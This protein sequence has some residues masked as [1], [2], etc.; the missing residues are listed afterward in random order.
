MKKHSREL[1]L[2]LT[3]EWDAGRKVSLADMARVIGT[4]RTIAFNVFE[5]LEKEGWIKRKFVNSREYSVLRR[6]PTSDDA[7][8]TD[9]EIAWCHLHSGAVR[10]IKRTM[11][12]E[13]VEA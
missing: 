2:Y 11:G 13:G 9:E 6:L 8:L 7:P 10:W 12:D 1:L 3:R 4:G 5:Y